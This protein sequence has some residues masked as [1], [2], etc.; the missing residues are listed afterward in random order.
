[1]RTLTWI[2]TSGSLIDGSGGTL[3][4]SS[5][6]SNLLS[7]VAVTGG[8]AL[9]NGFLALVDATRVTGPIS[10]TNA[11]LELDSQGVLAS[12]AQLSGGTLTFA[13]NPAAS[14]DPLFATGVD[15]NGTLLPGGSADPH[16]SVSATTPALVLSKLCSGWQPDTAASGWIGVQDSPAEPP[17]PY[18][19]TQTFTLTPAQ[20]AAPLY[21]R[22]SIDDQG[23]LSLNGKT[24]VNVGNAA[25]VLFRLD[26]ADGLESGS[27]TL[28]VTMTSSD[29]NYDGVRV[30]LLAP[31]VIAAG[32]TISGNGMIG[33]NP[34]GRG[35]AVIDNQ[36][37]VTA[38]GAGQGLTIDPSSF[39]NDGLVSAGN[40]RSL[41]I[42]PSAGQ[43]WL[44][45]ADGTIGATAATLDLGGGFTN[46]GRIATSGGALTLDLAAGIET[47]SIST[48][49]TAVTL[50]G[51]I[52]TAALA[53]LART[54]GTLTLTGTIDNT[55]A[56]IDATQGTFANLF[57]SGGTV[58]GGTVI[59]GP[60]GSIGIA[61]SATL[62]GVTVP[63]G[64]ALSANS[65]LDLA[66]STVETAAGAAPGTIAAGTG[67]LSVSGV[68]G[69]AEDV[70]LSGGLLAFAPTGLSRTGS[71]F[72]AGVDAGGTKRPEGSADPHWTVSTTGNPAAVLNGSAHWGWNGQ[73]SAWIG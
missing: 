58:I 43:T 4:A 71:L 68:T 44:N 37:T 5:S 33:D 8:L 21:G 73:G 60:G 16:W 1:M 34:I 42:D 69:L 61:G 45:N 10:L 17:A 46:L 70:T 18:S 53:G 50:Q 38:D 39:V 59:D 65:T 57:L 23:T 63:G 51:A 64:L 20:A 49:N 30:S 54:G 26:A 48:D 52:T 11:T 27:N 6:T 62:S 19:F 66:G 13:G 25:G 7:D 40:G 67:T 28:T 29:Q 15:A 32:T 31:D 24:L 41:S 3:A 72:A 22:V 56:T 2:S 55:G 9:S 12:N 47:G 14:A 35:T 36:G